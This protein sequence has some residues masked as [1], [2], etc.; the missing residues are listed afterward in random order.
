[1]TYTWVAALG[2]I[3]VAATPATSQ[4]RPQP[5][6]TGQTMTSDVGVVAFANSGK[7]SAQHAFQRGI[8]LLHNFEY[9]RA[10]EQFRSAQATDPGFAMAYW[11]EAMTHNHPI[12]MEQDRPAAQAVLARLG[13]TPAAR[14]AKARTQREK[15]YLT[16]VEILYGDGSKFD[17][18]QR[19][20]DAMA[21]IHA[22]YPRDV[23][24]TAFTALSILGTAHAGRDFATYM[25]AAAMLEE[26]FP[27]NRTHPGVLHYLI[28]SYDDPV[29]APLGLRAARRYGAVAPDA[30]HAL[31][32]TS[33]IFLALGLWDDVIAA[34]RQAIK[35]V[36]GQR[37]AA[38]RPS[39]G[40]GHY[41]NWLVYAYLQ[42][43]MAEEALADTAKC[44]GEVMAEK[45]AAPAA[46]AD[47]DNN[48]LSAWLFERAM[49]VAD[50]GKLLPTVGLP[51]AGISGWSQLLDGY[52]R[53]LAAYYAGDKDGVKAASSD[54]DRIAPSLLA[55]ADKS[56]DPQPSQRAMVEAMRLQGQALVKL[57]AGD[58]AGALADLDR[59]AAAEENAPIEFGP[60]M[61]A[62]PSRELQG[63]VLASLGRNAEAAT[64][65]RSALARAPGRRLSAQALARAIGAH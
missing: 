40:C 7:P 29:H 49:I 28:H 54:L 53:V 5:A 46:S 44:Q 14:L 62:K 50:G 36:D 33:H 8:A 22:A 9:E 25:R 10:A 37:A 39:V 31:H 30:G 6:A 45:A 24:A 17:R 34:N 56:D 23:D 42:K 21:R 52:A 47:P 57:G 65:Y 51:M 13:T 59:A 43:G 60:P 61:V 3:I 35:V 32:M 2:A 27:D 55:E 15:D 63:D 19:Y 11:G 18:D 1:M 20:A 26:V 48:A 58:N 41:P 64:A 12:W 4:S 38:G 16:A